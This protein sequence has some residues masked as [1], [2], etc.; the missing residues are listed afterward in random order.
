MHPIFEKISLPFVYGPLTQEE[1]NSVTVSK[2]LVPEPDGWYVG[3]AVEV[4]N[5]ADKKIF[6]WVPP[7]VEE[8]APPAE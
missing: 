7:V 8:E 6:K 1:V 2:A 5:L 3:T 4:S